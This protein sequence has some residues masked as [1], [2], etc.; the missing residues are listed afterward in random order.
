MLK[1]PAISNE[2]CTP[3]TE[4][5]RASAVG[6]A[7]P[8]SPD[9][10]T[11][12]A[13]P[14]SETQ[15]LAESQPLSPNALP[16]QAEVVEAIRNYVASY[17][18]LGFLHKAIFVERYMTSPERVSEFLLLA[19]CSIAAPFTPSLVARYRGKKR[20]TDFFL[21]RADQLLGREMVEPSLERAQ[22]FLL[23]GVTEWGQGNGSKAWMLIGTAVRMAGFLGLHREST[24]QLP[25]NPTPEAFIE[26]EIAR[27]TFWAITCH[28]NLL[29]GQSRPIQISLEEVDVLLPCEESE[30]NF[31][32]PPTSRSSIA[33]ILRG[34]SGGY[35]SSGQGEK[36]L[37]ASLVQVK[38]L[39]SLTARQACRGTGRFE[40]IPWSHSSRNLLTALQDFEVNLPIKH[41]FTVTNLRGMMVEGL[42]L[43]FLSI[44]LITRLSNI[45]IRRMYLPSMA[46][47]IDPEGTSDR[48]YES[49]DFWKQMATEMIWN[50]EQLLSQV[51][52]FFSMRS[53]QLGFPPIMSSDQTAV[54]QPGL[55]RL[56]TAVQSER[57]FDDEMADIYGRPAASIIGSSPDDR[58][59]QSAQRGPPSAEPVRQQQQQRLSPLSQQSLLNIP[60]SAQM[61]GQASSGT[62]FLG[63]PS[64]PSRPSIPSLPEPN[65]LNLPVEPGDNT[66]IA[67]DFFMDTFG[68]DLSAFLQGAVPVGNGDD[69]FGQLFFGVPPRDTL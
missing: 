58:S 3:S 65:H 17:F 10:S 42:D 31:G 49:H 66:A 14:S 59:G 23:L 57:N 55:S 26:S 53:V 56:R 62:E 38:I 40:T 7:V 1:V 27:R 18:Q 45:V 69:G 5:N 12:P 11:S 60:T 41:R 35:A 44:T 16:P 67:T 6:A 47:A 34:A 39:W 13:L 24:Y 15:H 22:A 61:I 48:D 9:T 32:I 64:I 20:A 50:S 25:P 21:A 52:T 36:S 68:D 37:F 4:Q 19:I 29:A 63:F 43:A 46:S 33:G 8:P 51:E 54:R 28:E 30:F 2:M